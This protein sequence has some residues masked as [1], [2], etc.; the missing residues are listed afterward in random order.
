MRRVVIT[1]VG[2]VSAIGNDRAAFCRALRESAAGIG[3]ITK[4]DTAEIRFK[5]AGE[6]KDFDPGKYF[7]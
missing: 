2:V 1:G 3:P 6:V 4:I 7:D 5:N